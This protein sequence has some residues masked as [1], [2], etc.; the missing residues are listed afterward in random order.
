MRD[1]LDHIFDQGGGALKALG[2]QMLGELV[3]EVLGLTSTWSECSKKKLEAL[4]TLDDE[5]D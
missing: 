4:L 5:F 1:I 2:C 3:A